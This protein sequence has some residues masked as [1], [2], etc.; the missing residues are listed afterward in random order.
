MILKH[1]AKS[2]KIFEFQANCIKVMYSI[3][4]SCSST[5]FGRISTKGHKIQGLIST[6]SATIDNR[7]DKHLAR[8]RIRNKIKLTP[9]ELEV[10]SRSG[11][12]I[13]IHY[14]KWLDNFRDL[15]L[16]GLFSS[17]EKLRSLR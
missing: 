4:G 10:F 2:S 6:I 13:V 16:N 7:K 8:D 12:Y 17:S 15:V 11:P 9:I 5:D 3:L 1:R 14:S